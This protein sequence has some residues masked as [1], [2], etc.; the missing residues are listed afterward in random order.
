MGLCIAL[1]GKLGVRPTAIL[2]A[3]LSILSIAF[4][5]E[6][7]KIPRCVAWHLDLSS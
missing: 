5:C 2:A 4:S 3:L 6:S 7:V 1:A